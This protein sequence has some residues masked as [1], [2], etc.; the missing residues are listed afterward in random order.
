[1]NRRPLANEVVSGLKPGGA[2]C[3]VFYPS[4]RIKAVLETAR[5]VC[6]IDRMLMVVHIIKCYSM[7]SYIVQEG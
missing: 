4:V 6:Y 1:M 2:Y 3:R 7:D 5:L